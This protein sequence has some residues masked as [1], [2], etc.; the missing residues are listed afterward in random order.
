MCST[1][2]IITT[3]YKN[4]IITMCNFLFTSPC[5]TAETGGITCCCMSLLYFYFLSLAC[6]CNNVNFPIV[7]Q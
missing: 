3:V 1:Q 7:G 4:N 2:C 5:T 6:C